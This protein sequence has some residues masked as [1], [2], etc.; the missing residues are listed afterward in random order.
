MDGKD[1][2]LKVT[3]AEY[4]ENVMNMPGEELIRRFELGMAW[5]GAK[6]LNVDQAAEFISIIA[7]PEERLY[8]AMW[9]LEGAIEAGV[10]AE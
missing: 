9:L 7:D 1:E 6:T 5:A 10:I 2:E 3:R 8:L 4:I